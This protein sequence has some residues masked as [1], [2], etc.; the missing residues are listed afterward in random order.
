MLDK[1]FKIVS[2]SFILFMEKLLL[3]EIKEI[4]EE[5]LKQVFKLIRDVFR[6]IAKRDQL[7]QNRRVFATE[8]LQSLTE[9]Y[10]Y[11]PN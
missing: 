3:L 4:K 7:D 8:I 10:L 11:A 6:Q 1:D 2:K 9:H 5:Q